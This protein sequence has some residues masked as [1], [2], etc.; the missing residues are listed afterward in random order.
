MATEI[1]VISLEDAFDI[2][3]KIPSEINIPK[4]EEHLLESLILSCPQTE[5]AGESYI[6]ME[7]LRSFCRNYIKAIREKDHSFL[8]RQRGYKG[9]LVDVET[10]LESPDYMNQKGYVR[11]VVKQEMERIFANADNITE[12]ILKGS[13]GWGKSYMSEMIIA[14]LLY[15]LSMLYNPQAEYELDPGSSIIFALQSVSLRLSKKILFD[16]LLS[17]L[18]SSKYFRENFAFNKNV[19][20][21]LQFPGNIFVMPVSGSEMATIG[22]NI[23]GGIMSEVNY[24]AVVE[25][26]K[27]LSLRGALDT[28]YD[29]AERAYTNI[30][31]RMKNRFLDRGKLP[32]FLILDSAAH[33]PGDFLDRKEEEAKNDHSIHVVKHAIWDTLPRDKFCGK[34]FLVEIGTLE[35]SSRIIAD[36]KLAI[37]GSDIIEVPIEYQKDFERDIETALRDFAGIATGHRR[38]FMPYKDALIEASELYDV[39]F[40]G[41]TLF[42]ET[43]FEINSYFDG[44]PD[45]TR[46][47]NPAYMDT[48]AFNKNATFALHVDLGYAK[49]CVGLAVAHIH[50]YKTLPSTSF[51]S[52]EA[53]DFIEVADIQAPVFCIDGMLQITP[54]AHSEIDL[55]LVRGF[56]FYLCKLLKAK[57]ATSDRFE[58][59]SFIQGFRKLKAISGNVSTVTTPIPYFELK[60]AYIETRMLHQAHPQYSQ[61]LLLLE[62][63]PKRNRIDH[64]T[65]N[66]KDIADAVASVV[67]ILQHKVATYKRNTRASLA[68]HRQVVV[69]KG[70]GLR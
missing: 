68:P 16:P 67:H 27:Q 9:P 37:T 44:H 39:I 13:T 40:E 21:E 55:E 22:L 65:E 2:V 46:L 4:F 19:T 69:T 59:A 8:I 70:R 64:T 30:I 14:Y 61:E 32:G 11:P 60:T 54:P 18:A 66:S 50:E 42:T 31:Q 24:F 26:S 33:Y 15:K 58:S 57:Y 41:H 1:S 29:Q 6:L 23:F 35:R 47:I 53:N 5:D 12:V 43:S 7:D 48:L 17:R 20:S 56:C 25:D 3:C 52:T 10:F 45:W 38:A 49:D 36:R 63:D 62:Y 51:Y 28:T 34:K